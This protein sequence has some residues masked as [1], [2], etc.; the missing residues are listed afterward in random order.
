MSVYTTINLDILSKF[1]RDYHLGDLVSYKGILGGITNTNYFIDTTEGRF[2]LTIYEVLKDTELPF[3]LDFTRYLNQH[4]V[5]CPAPVPQKNGQLFGHI[6][7]KPATLFTCLNGEEVLNPNEQ[8]CF[9][10]AAMLA[11]L[12][13]VSGHFNQ[14]MDNPRYHT[15]WTETAHK[16]KSKLNKYDFDLLISEINFLNNH[17]TENLPSGIIHADLFKD[18]VLMDND[19]VAGFIDFYY[20][21][22]GLFVYD[23]A[24]TLNDWARNDKN[25]IN[26]SLNAAMLLG[27]NSVRQL[28]VAE[29]AYLPIARRAGAIRFW[30]SRLLDLHFPLPGNMTFLKN[31]NDFRDLILFYHQ[32][33]SDETKTA[34]FDSL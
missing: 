8:Q 15:W 6:L 25:E 24:I 19:K 31:P 9:Q 23:L 27:Y 32:Y 3:Y 12:H 13:Q 33:Y 28:T 1:L 17:L 11:Q 10:V 7:N 18:N 34:P 5:A 26:T 30:V 20:A 4:Q 21:C 22:D 16:L 29:Q 14:H 2:V